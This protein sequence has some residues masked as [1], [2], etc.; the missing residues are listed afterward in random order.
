MFDNANALLFL[1]VQLFFYFTFWKF[2]QKRRQLVKSLLKRNVQERNAF[3]IA[4]NLCDS[5]TSLSSN[6]K[7]F[8]NFLDGRNSNVY[9]Y[10]IPIRP[11]AQSAA[12]PDAGSGRR[13]NNRRF[14]WY[15]RKNRNQIIR[16]VRSMDNEITVFVFFGKSSCK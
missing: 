16:N 12:P 1:I 9:E 10:F 5:L 15:F 8:Q 7:P 2:R 11:F 4:K 3:H 6:R 14:S 13:K